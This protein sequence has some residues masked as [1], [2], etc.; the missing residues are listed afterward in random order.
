M[1]W[2]R[3]AVV[4][5]MAMGVAGCTQVPESWPADSGG[6]PASPSPFPSS[7]AAAASPEAARREAATP[8]AATPEAATPWTGTWAV[9]VQP[10]GRSFQR[11]TLRQIV[12][13]SIGGSAARVRLSNAYGTTPLT[14]NSVYVA[15]RLRGSAIDAKTDRPVTFGGASTVIIPAGG[16][17]VSD[18]VAFAVPA[19]SDIAVSAYLPE[20]TG[21]ST[22]H[23][24]GG[25]HNYI[26]AGDQSAAATLA[27]STTTSSYFFL[28]GVDVQNPAAT[29]S[30]VAFGASITDGVGS[31]FNADRRWPDLLSDRLRSAGRTIGV[32]NTGI[33][34]NRLTADTHGA[35]AAKRFDRDVLRQPGVRW[36]IISDDAINDLGKSD[37]PAPQLITALRTLI[38]RGHDAGIKVICS[39]LTPF[40]GAG[41]WTE[42]GERGRGEINAFIRSRD[43]GCDAVLDLDRATRDPGSPSRFQRRYDSGDHLHPGDAGMRAIADAVELSWF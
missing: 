40:R 8:E 20:S 11:E 26:A 21:A 12:H 4:A 39:T 43:S 19:D 14:V 6:S 32:L 42:R 22:R 9:A 29:G 33:S 7:S 23:A 13:T 34:G 5:T 2:A 18:P 38:A 37:T 35:S 30:V 41:Y 1:K 36:V 25:R 28:A 15:R 31:K 3:K 10:R 27:G 17:A 16:S 24:V